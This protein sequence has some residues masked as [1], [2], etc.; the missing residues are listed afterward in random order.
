M[1]LNCIFGNKVIQ[2]TTIT[3]FKLKNVFGCQILGIINYVL[4]PHKYNIINV[5]K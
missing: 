5:I 2:K 3:I 1:K 4:N